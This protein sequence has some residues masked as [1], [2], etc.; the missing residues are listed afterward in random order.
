[1]S[2]N[3]QKTLTATKPTNSNQQQRN[4]SKEIQQL[5]KT[6]LEDGIPADVI[7]TNLDLLPLVLR[8]SRSGLQ[9]PLYNQRYSP[10]EGGY[11]PEQG[12]EA[13]GVH[14][15]Y[16]TIYDPVELFWTHKNIRDNERK[17]HE[18][19]AQE[20]KDR[21]ERKWY[22]YDQSVL[23]GHTSRLQDKDGKNV[24]KEWFYENEYECPRNNCYMRFKTE[25]EWKKHI[26]L[27]GMI[28]R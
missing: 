7:E 12:Y 28:Y 11:V 14:L 18:R 1:M 15:R 26:R 25:A 8:D 19:K 9:R 24:T 3:N 2:S 22:L 10:I 21:V 23:N 20:W 6:L 5:S 13:D 17:E 27:H 16:E 4:S